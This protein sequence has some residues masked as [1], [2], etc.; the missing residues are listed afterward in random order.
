MRCWWGISGL[1]LVLD[2]LCPSGA[3]LGRF[4]GLQGTQTLGLSET[5]I[6]CLA[7]LGGCPSVLLSSAF[8][9]PGLQPS[10]WFWKLR[11]EASLPHCSPEE[12]AQGGTKKL[13][14]RPMLLVFWVRQFWTHLPL[15]FLFCKK[16]KLYFLS[17]TLVMHFSICS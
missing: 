8:P 3:A 17:N 1:G 16:I 12:T 9:V 7:E 5:H 4:L 11:L 10:S 2:G 6:A 14:P 15:H 13:H